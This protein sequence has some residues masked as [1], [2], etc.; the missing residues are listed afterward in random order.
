L[1]TRTFRALAPI[2]AILRCCI[3][4]VGGGD[5]WCSIW[6]GGF[7]DAAATDDDDDSV[8]A[9]AVRDRS[10]IM[11]SDAAAL[12]SGPWTDPILAD[13][14]INVDEDKLARGSASFPEGCD[15]GN[16]GAR[17][18]F[19]RPGVAAATSLS[20]GTRGSSTIEVYRLKLPKEAAAAA[21]VE[22]FAAPK[23]AWTPWCEDVHA[24]EWPGPGRG[25]TGP[26]RPETPA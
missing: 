25:A 18:G 11:E 8:V 24:S 3:E 23:A 13:A 15:G 20:D 7:L 4:S 14:S 2:A 26:E 17:G 9:G 12:I 21:V 16:A 6:P 5:R 1:S 10:A 22:V 19:R